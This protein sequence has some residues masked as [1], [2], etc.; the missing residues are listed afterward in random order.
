MDDISNDKRP[1]T[2]SASSS[3]TEDMACSV[4]SG[5]SPLERAL[6]TL[7]RDSTLRRK[8]LYERWH[9]VIEDRPSSDKPHL[10]SVDLE[11]WWSRR[12]HTPLGRALARLDRT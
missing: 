3:E 9:G 12:L 1:L 6:M 11:F 8:Y 7:S 2:S 5:S 4:R 10:Y